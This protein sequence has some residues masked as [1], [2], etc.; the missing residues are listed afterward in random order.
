MIWYRLGDYF[1][2]GSERKLYWE[3]G[4]V[5]WTLIKKKKKE[6]RGDVEKENLSCGKSKGWDTKTA[7]NVVH[8]KEEKSVV[9]ARWRME[10]NIWEK[11]ELWQ[12]NWTLFYRQ[13]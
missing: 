1:V 4:N 2:L 11:S 9:W 8:L 6:A 5:N 3:G 7:T 10:K 12:K 13:M